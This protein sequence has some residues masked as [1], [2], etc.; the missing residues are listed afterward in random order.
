MITIHDEVYGITALEE[1]VLEAVIATPAMQRLR[2]VSQSGVSG[3]LGIAPDYSRFA[4]SAGVMLLLRRLGAPLQEQIA[5]LLHDISHTAFSHVA[6]FVYDE[7]EVSYHERMWYSVVERSTIPQILAQHGYDW[8]AMDADS[9]T[10]PLLEQPQPRLCADRVDYFLR[11]VVPAGLGTPEQVQWVLGHLTTHD[12]Q[13]VLDDVGAARWMAETYMAMDAQM[14]SSPREAGLYWALARAMRHAV[15][16][17]YIVE[18]DW[19][20]TD[21]NLWK[22][23]HR[24]RD[25][26]IRHLL[27]YVR[28]DTEV[29]EGSWPLEG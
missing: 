24:I 9:G 11:T 22:R 28:A 29:V 12:N 4:H 15:E 1:P 6:D 21:R 14:W 16:R 19:Y 13:I 20:D 3:L 10:F 17:G 26:Q 23:L 7:H 5:G 2:Y 27:S 18:E 8:K 25:P